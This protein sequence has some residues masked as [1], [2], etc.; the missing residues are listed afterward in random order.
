MKKIHILVLLI[1][2]IGLMSFKNDKPAYII[3]NSKGKPVKYSK[4]LKKLAEANILFIGEY[5]NNPISHWM[6]YE[7]TKDLYKLR[8]GKITMGAEMFEADN[9]II[10]DEYLAG[11]ISSSKFESECKLWPNYSTDYE[12]LITFAKDSSLKFIATNI[13]RRY[14]SIV[15]KKGPELLSKLSDE[16][17]KYIVPLPIKFEADSILKKQLGMMA[18]M[19]KNPVGIMKA[20]I[21]KDKTMAYFIMKNYDKERMFIHYNG[22]FHS[23]S[24]SG[25]VKY[26]DKDL[27]VITI[28]TVQQ[29]DISKLDPAYKGQADYIICIPYSMT[30][31]Y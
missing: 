31:T 5:H 4:M 18:M 12:P 27:K 8:D 28:S 22:T 13:P 16:A 26:I 20:Q 30:R 9:Q 3:Y 25:I 19:S 23:D 7:I 14:A 24:H 21:I 11:Y 10:I 15:H 1:L 29:D 6:E 17:K 2:S